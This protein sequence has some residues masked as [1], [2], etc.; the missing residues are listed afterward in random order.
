[1][2]AS[3]ERLVSLQKELADLRESGQCN[4][5][6]MAAGKRRYSEGAGKT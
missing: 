4:E 2:K 5:S 6:K 1:M 3:K